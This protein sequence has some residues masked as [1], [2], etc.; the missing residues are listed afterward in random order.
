MSEIILEEISTSLGLNPADVNLQA[1][2]VQLGGHSLS[3]A[4]LAAACKKRGFDTPVAS[5]LTEASIDS[6]IRVA[7][8]NNISKPRKTIGLEESTQISPGF[9]SD[10]DYVTPLMTSSTT[11]TSML[12]SKE[13]RQD[14]K[15]TAEFPLKQESPHI[16]SNDV[17]GISELI[18]P[19]W[20][21]HL[22]SLTIRL[23]EK[24]AG[25]VNDGP[26][27]V[28]LLNKEKFGLSDLASSIPLPSAQTPSTN[29]L[30]SPTG[31]FKLNPSPG[32]NMT[33]ANWLTEM[34][35]SLLQGSLNDP[36][37]NFIYYNETYPT[38]S[39]PRMKKA[40]FQIVSSEPIFQIQEYHTG[41]DG[42]DNYIVIR[43]TSSTSIELNWKEMEAQDEVTYQESK[44]N[45]ENLFDVQ[46]E[47]DLN[48]LHLEVQ[49]R[50]ITWRGIKN[51]KNSNQSTI[52]WRI[53]HA[54]IDGFSASLV[55]RK[56]RAAKQGVMPT[57]G[58]PFSA[59]A[60]ELCILQTS[61]AQAG[62]QY[63]QEHQA[64]LA[65][66]TK[67]LLLPSPDPLETGRLQRRCAEVTTTLHTSPADLFAYAQTMG[68]TPA[69]ILYAAW[70]LVLSNYTDSDATVVGAVMSGRN[71]SLP[72]VDSVIGPL[73]NTLPFFIQID[74]TKTARELMRE[75]FVRLVRLATYQWT[76]PVNGFTRDFASALAIQFEM[77]MTKADDEDLLESPSSW[78]ETDIPLSLMV[79]AEG[80]IR[81]AYQVSRYFSSDVER[82]ASSL[83][84]AV[85]SLLRPESTVQCCLDSLL[86]CDDQ[87]MLQTY[88]NCRSGLTTHSIVKDD[89]VT[90]FERA[91]TE[92][93]NGI[94]LEKGGVRMTYRELDV[95][96]DLMAEELRIESQQV[97]CLHADKSINWIV[98]IW[99]ILKAGGVYCA[100][101]PSLPADLRDQVY[102]S[103]G[104]KLFLSP[105]TA[106]L[107]SKPRSAVGTFDIEQFITD[108]KEVEIPQQHRKRPRPSRLAYLCFT[109]GSTGKPKGVMCSHEGLVA[110][111]RDLEV[112]LFAQPG[113]RI[114]Q[115]MSVAFDGSIHE[116]F[117]AL[118][119]G[120]T[121][122]LSCS[123]D[124]FEPVRTVDSAILTPS[125]AAVLD[126]ASF[127]TLSAVSIIIS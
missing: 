107:A 117:S 12:W 49:F 70:A 100:L 32:S 84:D 42:V 2:F 103:G 62:N 115:F 122:V 29:S 78:V 26:D 109:S 41:A 11:S 119:Y 13:E 74:R 71:L 50:V 104:A 21:Q 114:S 123:G 101:D 53:H 15:H 59:L 20:R 113:R 68:V 77:P 85:Q 43:D 48:H 95:L 57:T 106:A 30:E 110:F 46:S 19:N 96:A 37:T 69:S 86:T 102:V 118:C 14:G 38:E 82:L 63:W 7:Q 9:I 3:A 98:G 28:S 61:N 116:I 64:S 10:E 39:V 89:L 56:L 67:D 73:I 6:L 124:P 120:A 31:M 126:P 18:L 55:F 94:A 5:I 25:I 44:E 83:G 4:L 97:V 1:S 93:P 60:G 17:S 8:P 40:W 54:L 51:G 24:T 34:Q 87:R 23:P 76:T 79:E 36:R 22:E 111:Q 65:S 91:V 52:I 16:E 33:N 80:T 72:Y 112:R 108:I 75:T 58:P 81:I 105:S 88:G 66:G 92:T 90:L 127:P 125:I 47:M 99:A 27:T 121:L 35:L 45:C